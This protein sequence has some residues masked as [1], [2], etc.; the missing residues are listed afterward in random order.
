MASTTKAG[1]PQLVSDRAYEAIVDLILTRNLRAGER[2]SVKLLAD[3]LGLGR[4]PIKEAITRL[5]AEGVLAVAGRSGTTVKTVSV[6]ETRQILAL[7]RILEDFAA[8]E[9]VR[10]AEASDFK[11]LDRLLEELRHTSLDVRG[12]AGAATSRFV[13]ANVAF[14]AALVG[15]AR[16]PFLDRLYAQIQMQVQIVTYLIH[17]GHDP[18]AASIRQK[19]HEQIV[20]ALERRD[21]AM[22]KRLL[23]QHAHA[24]ESAILASLGVISDASPEHPASI[25]TPDSK[26]PRDTRRHVSV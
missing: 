13:R 22:L 5:E 23:K 21:A 12:L 10:C 19:E 9:A 24:T 20:K 3:R 16:N 11:A 26:R 17:R 4:T 6:T 25:S 8:D 2:T 1:E 15:A 14:H 18:K 7:R